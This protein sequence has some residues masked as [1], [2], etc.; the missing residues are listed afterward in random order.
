M[1]FRSSLANARGYGSARRG[2]A[3]WLWQRLTALLLIPLMVWLSLVLVRWPGTAAVPARAWLAD[4]LHTVLISATLPLLILH[5]H[6]GLQTILED[7]VHSAW[8]RFSLLL[9]IRSSML[10]LGTA[11]LLALWHIEMAG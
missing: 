11:A 1:N 5:A 2:T 3:T 8:L 6:T 10:L 4:P 9:L 7:Y